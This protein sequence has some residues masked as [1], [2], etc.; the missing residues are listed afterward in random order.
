L[1]TAS[2]ALKPV[3]SQF[4][5]GSTPQT[6]SAVAIASDPS[7]DFL[8][9]SLAT[10][11]ESAS[12]KSLACSFIPAPPGIEPLAEQWFVLPGRGFGPG[13]LGFRRTWC[14]KCDARAGLSNESAIVRHKLFFRLTWKY[15]AK[16][17]VDMTNAFLDQVHVRLPSRFVWH[18]HKGLKGI[19][20]MVIHEVDH[21]DLFAQPPQSVALVQIKDCA[22]NQAPQQVVHY[23]LRS[24]NPASYR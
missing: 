24:I 16:R 21:K 5:L 3:T 1:H 14:P 20:D 4:A 2:A 13:I 7:L 6:G 11:S 10:S 19:S 18:E 17:P 23:A 9:S 15:F 8:H 22:C 12:R